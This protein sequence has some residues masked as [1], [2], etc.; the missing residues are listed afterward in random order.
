M[1]G[2]PLAGKRVLVTRPKQRAAGLEALIR[3]AGGE[4]LLWP[5]IE[6]GDPADPGALERTLGR[7]QAFDLAIFIS[8]TAVERGLAWIE[9][10]GSPWPTSLP[11]GAIGPGTRR[12]LARRGFADVIAPAEKPDSEALLGLPVLQDVRG[13]RVVIFRGSGGRELLASVLADRGATVEYAECYR[14][15][16]APVPG[17]APAW[18]AAALHAVTVSS[19]EALANVVAALGRWR[20]Q[21]AGESVLFVPHRRVGEAA[22]RLGVRD[23]IVAGASDE[24][25]ATRLVAYFRDAK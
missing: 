24:E 9:R 23:V 11:V 20:P 8:P 22:A 7:L 2:A 19:A 5:A 14:R 6:I 25:I 4:P 16:A 10:L 3:A 1:T 21:W 18:A 15:I 17:V 12:E 13:K